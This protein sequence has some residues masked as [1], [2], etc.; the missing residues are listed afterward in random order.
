MIWASIKMGWQDKR[1]LL[2]SI[3]TVFT[4]IFFGMLFMLQGSQ[5]LSHQGPAMVKQVAN[6]MQMSGPPTHGLLGHPGGMNQMIN[7]T[8][9]NGPGDQGGMDA[10][11]GMGGLF[12]SDNVILFTSLMMVW[13][14]TNRFLEGV[15]TGLVYS[16]LTEGK[17]AGKFSSAC[18]AVFS[19]LPAIVMLGLVT[20]IAKKLAGWM[21]NKRNSG[22]LG[23]GFNFLAGVVEVFWTL[24]GHLIL[25]AI[26]IEG[27]SFW[28]GLKRADKIAQGNLLTIGVGE[29]GVDLICRLTTWVVYIG[30]LAGF[31][32][33][34]YTHANPMSAPIIAGTLFW[35]STVVLV[36]ALS[37]YI[38]AAFYTCLYVWAIEAEAVEEADRVRVKPPEPLAL[39]L[40]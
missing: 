37:I 31:G 27:T 19:S 34:Y 32:A 30:G 5:K 22:M 15:T 14:L 29:V 21:R 33:I 18:Q 39:A 17:G 35:A 11:S 1:L 4:N 3:L 28:G 10:M 16:H 2:P 12:S 8:S 36:T 20:L 13:W 24:A 40:S 9:L 7:M 38:R 6:P 23:M 26:V 25:P